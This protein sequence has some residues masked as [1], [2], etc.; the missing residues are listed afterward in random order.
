MP[1]AIPPER[2]R[3]LRR[4]RQDARATRASRRSTTWRTSSPTTAVLASSASTA[5]APIVVV[6]TPPEVSLY[7]RFENDLFADVLERLRRRRGRAGAAAGGAAARRRPARGARARARLRGAR[8]RDRRAVADRAR[9]PRDLRR[10]HDEPRGGRAG[11]AGL[12]HL[13]GSPGRGRRTPDRRRAAAHAARRRGARPGQARCRRCA[14]RACDAIRAFSSS[15]CSRPSSASDPASLRGWPYNPLQCA[16]GSAR[17]PS[18]STVTRCRSS[19]WTGRWSRSRT[20]SPSSC[21]SATGRRDHYAQLRE[22]TIWWV[23]AREP[24]DPGPLRAST[25]AAGATP[26]S[27]TTRRSCARDRR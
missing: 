6:R 20:T 14:R 1:D 16:D 22:R 27:A 2:L 23:L 19:R 18:P 7:H 26:A 12:H 21:A 25:S 3:A 9:R 10:G 11:D 5:P 4:A 17:R 8:A 13:R 24:A 15:C